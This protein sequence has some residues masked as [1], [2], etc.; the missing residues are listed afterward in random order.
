M[1]RHN[2]FISAL[3]PHSTLKFVTILDLNDL[4]DSFST[5]LSNLSIQL[6]GVTN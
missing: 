4:T 6:G 5:K 1:Q 3:L 2:G